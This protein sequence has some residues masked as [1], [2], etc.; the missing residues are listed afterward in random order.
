MLNNVHPEDVE[1]NFRHMDEL[2]RAIQSGRVTNFTGVTAGATDSESIT[3]LITA[4]NALVDKLNQS[5]ITK[6]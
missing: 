6:G 5:I 4:F 1:K 3:N 2:F